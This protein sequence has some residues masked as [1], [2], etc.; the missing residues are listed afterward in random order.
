MRAVDMYRRQEDAALGDLRTVYEGL[1]NKM[2]KEGAKVPPSEEINGILTELLPGVSLAMNEIEANLY[3]AIV[4]GLAA[5]VQLCIV[6]E[7]Q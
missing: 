6:R 2:H 5:L 1:W 4:T 3:L 7:R